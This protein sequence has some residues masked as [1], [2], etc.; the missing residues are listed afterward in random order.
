MPTDLQRTD[1]HPFHGLEIPLLLVPG[2]SLAKPRS[3][4]GFMLAPAPQAKTDS[5][6]KASWQGLLPDRPCATWR[7]ASNRA[8]RNEC[9]ELSVELFG[10]LVRIEN[11]VAK[12]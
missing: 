1:C 2:V 4:P 7:F 12:E 8:A 9:V 11:E 10:L 5:S 6:Y 3:T